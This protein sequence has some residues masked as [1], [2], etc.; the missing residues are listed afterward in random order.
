MTSNQQAFAQRLGFAGLIP[1]LA[2]AIAALLGL[3]GAAATLVFAQYSAIILSFL[4]GVH[5]GIAMQTDRSSRQFGWSMVPSVI[6]IGALLLSWFIS[7][8][9]VLAV[10]ALTHLFWLNYERRHFEQQ[11]G[12]DWY[13][14][15]RRQLTFTVVAL[16][17][18]LMIISWS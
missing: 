11:A 3:Y 12:V 10:L 18:I 13:I 15:L 7:V 4:G 5:W 2:T 14:Q 17:V 1:F 8:T 9:A 16:H 6:A